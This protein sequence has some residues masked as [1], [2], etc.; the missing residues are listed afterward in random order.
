[1]KQEETRIPTIEWIEKD[2]EI[3]H[4]QKVLYR[5]LERQ[6]SFDESGQHSEDNGSES[7]IIYEDNLESLTA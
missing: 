5:D 7:M 1:M 6:Y 2:K 4:H 3:N